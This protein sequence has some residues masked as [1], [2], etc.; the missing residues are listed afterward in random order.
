MIAPVN[1]CTAPLRVVETVVVRI[2]DVIL[3]LGAHRCA[4]RTLQTF[5][6]RNAETLNRAGIALWLPERTRTGLFTGLTG[7]PED[8]TA[9]TARRAARACGL[10]RIETERARSK[11]MQQVIVS[12][13]NMIGTP[14]DNL[15]QAQLYPDLDRRLSRF[16]EAFG[17]HCTRIGLAIRSHDSFWASA[18]AGAVAQGHR[19]PDPAGIDRLVSQPRRW[20]D[21]IR[22]IAG[23]FP[24]A[25]IH[26]WPFERFA[27]QPDRQLAILSAGQSGGLRLTGRREWQNPSPRLD[28]LRDILC[29][30]GDPD[31]A[32]SLPP[33]PDRWTP[34]DADQQAALRSQYQADLAWLRSDAAGLAKLI[35]HD[36]IRPAMSG[37][38]PIQT[39]DLT[40][41]TVITGPVRPRRP[42][43]GGNRDAKQGHLG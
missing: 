19:L 18:L 24:K 14:R 39:I 2:V 37:A 36:T 42:A 5:L 4:T 41:T 7:H 15:R 38:A 3:H 27:A 26:V 34:F 29:Q 23:I 10:I 21:V 1:L 43:A 33:G 20:R 22:D 13:A 30:R 25:D 17:G 12:Q 8:A 35:E 40:E 31:S 6:G 11:G 16:Q 32:S 9:I 28:H